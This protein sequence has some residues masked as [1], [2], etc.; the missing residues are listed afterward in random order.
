MIPSGI[1][2]D[3]RGLP[4]ISGQSV[5]IGAVEVQVGNV[6]GMVKSAINTP[7]V[8]EKVYLDANNNSILDGGELSTTTNSSGAYIF[9]DVPVGAYIVRQVLQVG[10][11]QTSPADGYGNHITITSNGS[12]TNKNFV[13]T[14]PVTGGSVSGIVTAGSTG[15][16]GETIYLDANNNSGARQQRAIYENLGHGCL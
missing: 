15:V 12:L 4:R 6:S 2:T 8:G 3:Q 16:S 7:I 10:Y 11:A 1:A 5:D 13:D 14:A 9:S